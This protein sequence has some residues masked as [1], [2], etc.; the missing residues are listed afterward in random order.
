MLLELNEIEGH[1][2]QFLRYVPAALYVLQDAVA[3]TL[4]FSVVECP[5]QDA[6]LAFHAPLAH[7][8]IDQKVEKRVVSGGNGPAEARLLRFAVLA[9]CQMVRLFEKIIGEGPPSRPSRLLHFFLF[10]TAAEIEIR[11]QAKSC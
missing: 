1:G 9:R 2:V 11:T 3:D 5:R 8:L 6:A 4:H 10:G 7:G